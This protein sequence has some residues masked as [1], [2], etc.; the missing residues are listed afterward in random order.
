MLKSWFTRK[1][2]DTKTKEGKSNEEQAHSPRFTIA[3]LPLGLP[4]EPSCLAV[5]ATQSLLAVGGRDG[6]IR[7]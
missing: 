4:P 3:S 2:G 1:D 6:V 5:D 7:L